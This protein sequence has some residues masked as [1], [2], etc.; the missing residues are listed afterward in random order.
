MKLP[1]K[2]SMLKLRRQSVKWIILH[3]TIEMYDLPQARIDT[4][5]YQTSALFKGVLEK[6]QGDVNYHYVVEKIKEDYVP[7]VLRPFPYMCE[8]D[9]IRPDINNRSIHIALLGDYNFTIP[10][11]RLY[12]ILAYKLLNPFMKMY[13]LSPSRIKFHREVSDNKDLTCPGDFVDPAIIEA[14]VRKFVLK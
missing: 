2:P 14:M 7:I 11:K 10:S 1:L 9:D 6:K 12:E 5:K 8:W 13:R 4:P 3:S